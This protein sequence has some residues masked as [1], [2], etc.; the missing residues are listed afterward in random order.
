MITFSDSNTPSKP[1]FTRTNILSVQDSVF[2]LNVA[3][4]HE[5]LNHVSSIAVQQSLNLEYLPV[6]RITRGSQ[7]KLIKKALC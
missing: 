2:K 7:T 3:L 1:L 5:I 4:A 6:T